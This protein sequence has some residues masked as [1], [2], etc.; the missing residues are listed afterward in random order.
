MK[1]W[2][3]KLNKKT[4]FL[5]F[6][7]RICII[8]ISMLER[9]TE[10]AYAKVNF[11]LKVFPKREDGF[12]NIE[13]VFQTI[14]LYNTLEI[15]VTNTKDCEV[16]CLNADIPKEN[17]LTK[18]YQAFCQIAT[19]K[20]PGVKVQITKGIPDGGGLG[21]SSSDA[22]ALVRGLEKLCGITLSTEQLDFI[23]DKTGSDVFFFLHCDSEGTGCALVSG[24]GEVVKKINPRYDLFLLL[25]FPEVRIST[26][27]AYELV[28]EYLAKGN[29]KNRS[30]LD[31]LENVYRTPVEEWAYINTFSYALRDEF[32]ELEKAAKDLQEFGALFVQM[33]GSGSTMYGVFGNEQQAIYAR[34]LLAETW[35]CKT[36]QVVWFVL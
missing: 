29:E 27:L 11:G 2:Y 36:V 18:A 1:I 7:F 3:V 21:G 30:T 19:V 23:A 34:N 10:R 17:T 35:N 9:T 8:I 16:I 33:S 6:K 13:S 20:V 32:L 12:H 24:R 4:I 14:D 5:D 28:D 15:S 25:I 26:K 31:E 22:A